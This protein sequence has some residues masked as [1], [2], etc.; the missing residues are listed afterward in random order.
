MPQLL[1]QPW[2]VLGRPLT[3]RGCK[4]AATVAIGFVCLLL[5]YGFIWSCYRFRFNPSSDPS[6]HLESHYVVHRHV[7]LQLMLKDTSHTHLPTSQEVDATT[8]D[9]VPRIALFLED[10]HILPE[11]FTNGIVR[12]YETG[13]RRSSFLI[14]QYSAYGW[15]YYFPL[16]F[17][18]KT[19]LATMAAIIL[20]GA[21]SFRW[22]RPAHG[23]WTAICIAVP[24]AIYSLSL[25]AGSINLGI[26]HLFPIYPF[27]FIGVGMAFAHYFK[28]NQKRAVRIALALGLG[29]A[30]E[31]L[32]A[33][34]AFI[35]FF[36]VASGGERGGLAC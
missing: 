8:P 18:F 2:V 11:P 15:W 31:S 30:A 21:I 26:R 9:L 14:G 13:T 19:P 1:P 16:A 28:I 6:F 22:C 3:S 34:P 36:N 4:L 29:L 24:I 7:E 32:A 12:N 23:A 5:S 33:F 27:V 20:A 35:P 17:I 25:M 10:H